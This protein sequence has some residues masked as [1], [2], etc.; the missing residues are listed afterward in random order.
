MGLLLNV[1]SDL[2]STE[3]I[4]ET[5]GQL[6][7][8]DTLKVNSRKKQAYDFTTRKLSVVELFTAHINGET[9]SC[10]CAILSDYEFC[11]INNDGTMNIETALTQTLRSR[12][13]KSI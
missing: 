1:S 13:P 3:N 10:V 6:V 12:N 9:E 4:F 5:L 2:K 7:K 11:D 8:C